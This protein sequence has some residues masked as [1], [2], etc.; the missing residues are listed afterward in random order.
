MSDVCSKCNGIGKIR[1]KTC[2]GSVMKRCPLC[3]GTKAG[4][5]HKIVGPDNT[6]ATSP[7]YTAGSN[8]AVR[9]YLNGVAQDIIPGKPRRG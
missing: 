4:R 2:G 3:K 7:E 1:C 6:A 9:V 8:G 5:A